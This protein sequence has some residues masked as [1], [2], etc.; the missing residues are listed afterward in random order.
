MENDMSLDGRIEALYQTAL[1]NVHQYV[2]MLY[3]KEHSRPSRVNDDKGINIE[4]LEKYLKKRGYVANNVL[5]KR[6]MVKAFT[7]VHVTDECVEI[8]HDVPNTKTFFI[9]ESLLTGLP[10]SLDY[11]ERI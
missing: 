8:W 9:N 11:M 4:I 1:R 3:I 2:E 6:V 5:G 10:I 7:C